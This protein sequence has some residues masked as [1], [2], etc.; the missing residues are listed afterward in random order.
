MRKAEAL[1]AK[2]PLASAHLQPRAKPG[3]EELREA[4][5]SFPEMR[6]YS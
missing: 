1:A 4:V 3:L 6:D 2:E 5:T